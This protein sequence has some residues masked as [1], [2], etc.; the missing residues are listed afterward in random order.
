VALIWQD[1]PATGSPTGAASF[2]TLASLTES[3]N[4]VAASGAAQTIPSP[5]LVSASTATINDIT[6]T[7]NCTLTFPAATS[8]TSFLLFLR[9]DAT[10]SRT[11]TWPT[12]KWPAAVVPTLSTAANAIDVVS[13]I[14]VAGAWYGFIPGFDMR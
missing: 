5:A 1:F 6:L 3:V 14:C 7:A 12:V 2:N 8:G 13:F 9:Q 10:G 11:V 4:T